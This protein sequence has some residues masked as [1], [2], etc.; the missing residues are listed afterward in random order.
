MRTR[1]RKI[2]IWSY[3]FIAYINL[4]WSLIVIFALYHPEFA[5]DLSSGAAWS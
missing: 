4:F 3:V 2:T 1:L 5:E